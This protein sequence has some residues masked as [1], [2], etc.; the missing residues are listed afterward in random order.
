MQRLAEIAPWFTVSRIE[1]YLTP[2]ITQRFRVSLRA[3][4]WFVTNYCKGSPIFVGGADG[5]HC[6]STLYKL[7]LRQWRRQLF[8]PFRRRAR[9]FFLAGG[10][11]RRLH[12]TTC[13]QLNFLY[14][15][16]THGVLRQAELRVADVERDM[17]S[18]LKRSR[19]E[20]ESR[21]SKRRRTVLT[22]EPSE[23]CQV[24]LV[25]APLRL[26]LSPQADRATA[27]PPAR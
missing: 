21:G 5:Y 17:L 9:V 18:A 6:V 23:R 14:W 24:F 16:D 10:E 7:W 15:A 4:D 26:D 13:A 11:E 2:M 20:R 22:P 12:E 27:K 3:L 8:D 19:E 1:S 25:N